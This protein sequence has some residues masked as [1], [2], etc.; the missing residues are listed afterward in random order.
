MYIC[1]IIL[2]KERLIKLRIIAGYAKGHKLRCL[3]G[4]NTRPTLD[5]V[6]E[7]V[8]NVLGDRVIDAIFLDLFSGS[9]AI[10]IEALSRGAEICYFNEKNK[11]A[12]EIIKNNATHCRL[13]E[14][15]VF[16]SMDAKALLELL[17]KKDICF[18]IV[19]IDP[20]YASDLYIPVM[21]YL[22]GSSLIKENTIII[23]ESNKANGLPDDIN[24][25]IVKKETRYGDTVIRYYQH[26]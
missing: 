4:K 19:Y 1:G 26:K 23:C 2:H 20:P 17:S 24:G 13:E 12:Y 3:K 9:G 8:F 15:A 21:K 25:I 16:F 22:A 6:R 11:N 18:D 10:G 14:K 7:A 5:R